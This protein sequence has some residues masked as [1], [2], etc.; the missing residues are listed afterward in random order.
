MGQL[1]NEKL[2]RGAISLPVVAGFV[3]STRIPKFLDTIKFLGMCVVNNK[4]LEIFYKTS[5]NE[6]I[7]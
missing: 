1:I 4:Q 3:F 2:R 5:S 6:A 7:T